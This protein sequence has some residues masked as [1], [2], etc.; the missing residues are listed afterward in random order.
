[1]AAISRSRTI[2]APPQ[3]IWDVLADF[4]HLSSWA[5]GVDHSCVLNRGPDG[6]PVGTTRRVQVG[7]NALVE[8]ITE[9]DPPVALAYQIDGLPKRLGTVTNRWT[10]RPSGPETLV[11]LDTSVE[12]GASRPARMAE[13]VTLRVL[14]KQSDKLLAGLARRLETTHV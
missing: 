11:S 3:Q 7:P 9:F 12:V 1:M 5:D 14:A 2:A 13:W 6:N 4:G 8:R 10:L